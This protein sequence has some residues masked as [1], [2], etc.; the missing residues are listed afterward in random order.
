MSIKNRVNLSRANSKIIMSIAA[1]TEAA[2]AIPKLP[3]LSMSEIPVVLPLAKYASIT[4]FTPTT[5]I[6]KEMQIEKNKKDIALRMIIVFVDSNGT[7]SP[8]IGE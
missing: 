1:T 8:V 2:A 4:T 5:S 7:I 6:R 3:R